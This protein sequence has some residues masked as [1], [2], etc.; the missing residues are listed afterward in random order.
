MFRALFVAALVISGE[1]TDNVVITEGNLG[2][3]FTIPRGELLWGGQ[4]SPSS[5][6]YTSTGE[7]DQMIIHCIQPCAELFDAADFL[8]CVKQENTRHFIAPVNKRSWNVVFVS[9][10]LLIG[11]IEK[12]PGPA[13][14]NT[15]TVNMGLINARSIVNKSALIHDVIKDNKLDI[16]AVTETWVYEDSPKVHKREAAPPGYS[17]L[18]AHRNV[19]PVGGKKQH[20]GGVVL[21]HREDIRIKVVPLN[22][23]QPTTFEL[24]LVKIINCTLGLTIAIIYRP[25]CSS[26]KPVEFTNEL[27]DMIDKGLL[28]SRFV[29]C[30]DLNCPGPAGSKGQVGRELAELCDGYSLVQHIKDPTHQSGNILDHILSPGGLVSINDV[31]IR[32]VGLSDHSLITCKLV[33]NIKRQPIIR[34]SF[35]NWKKLDLDMFKQR[36]QSSPALVSPANTADEFA[37]QLETSITDILDEL[38]PTCSSTKRQGK[39]ESKWLSKEAMEAKQARRRL[40]RKWKS[41]GVETVRVA[42]R[43]TCRRANRLITESRRAFYSQRINNSSRD[44]RA[45]WRCV[46]GLLHTNNA[47]VQHEPGMSNRFSAFFNEKIVKAKTNILM[48]RSQSPLNAPFEPSDEINSDSCLHSLSEVSVVEVSRLIARL[49]NKTS[50]LDYIHTSVLKAC[51]DDLS[52]QIARLANLSFTEGKF[53]DRFKVAQV[54]PLIKKDGLD[55]TDPANYRPISNLN[56]IS[57]IIERLCLTRVLPHVA[58]TGRFNSLQS[59]YRKHHSTETALLKI[60]DDLYRITDDSKSAVLIGLDLSAAFDTIEHDI[61]IK[62]METMFGITGT[63]LRWF[64]TYLREREQYVVV[65]GERSAR[66]RCEFGVPQGSVLGP[67]LFSVYVSPISEVITSRGIQLHQ[68]ADDTQLY[69]AV[70]SDADIRKLEECTMAVRDWFT[71]NGMLLNP[72]K[73]EILLVA[74][75]VNAKKFAHG[76][77]ISVAGSNITFSV[78]LK[79]LGVTLDQSLSFDQHVGNIVKA[80]N[81]NICALR[82]IRPMLDRSIA[83]TIACSIVST[84]LDY[85]NSLLYGTSVKNITRLQRVQNTLARVVSGARRRDHIRP[86]LKDLHWLPVPQRIQYKVALITHKTLST[87]QPPYLHNLISEHKPSRHLRSEGQRLLSKPTGLLSAQAS[88]AFTRASEKVWNSLPDVV[89]K[90]NSLCAFKK[91]LK[92]HLFECANCT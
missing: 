81:F 24:L 62:R 17:I 25:P 36:L 1:R 23:V 8:F 6:I 78:Q 50:P 64:G 75:K 33:M 58:A 61:M 2:V 66:T 68:Y 20:G 35:R 79:S 38:A 44:P 85:C 63:A 56:T 52:P 15:S 7:H 29:I 28:R 11:G 22:L 32:D 16:L 87:G 27:S 5:T 55:S 73:S 89:R 84:R 14:T 37:S 19:S 30:G 70:K 47:S 76:M 49:P 65:G 80:S 74:R 41:T 31:T 45:L 18:H 26:S 4:I 83:N 13:R 72:D 88:K 9:A 42:Y 21:I 48:L 51:S 57:K 54:T 92:T 60:M 77:G 12:N 40:E 90:T 86:V 59:A 69:I 53:P 10:L 39:A 34:A 91:K 43:E 71:E 3:S 82:H 67:F 46:K